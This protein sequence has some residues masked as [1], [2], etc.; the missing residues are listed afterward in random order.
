[1]KRRIEEN[2]RKTENPNG[3]HNKMDMKEKGEKRKHRNIIDKRKQ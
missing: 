3:N 1:M 2:Q